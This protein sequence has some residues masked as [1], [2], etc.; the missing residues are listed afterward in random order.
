MSPRAWPGVFLYVTIIT[1]HSKDAGSSPAWRMRSPRLWRLSLKWCYSI[2]KQFKKS[3][4]CHTLAQRHPQQLLLGVF[5]RNIFIL[6]FQ[7]IPGQFCLFYTRAISNQLK[8]ALKKIY[9][10]YRKT[11]RYDILEARCKIKI[12]G[13]SQPVWYSSPRT[14]SGVFMCI[15]IIAYH[16]KDTGSRPV[17]RMGSPRLWRLS[18]AWWYSIV[19]YVQKIGVVPHSSTTSPPTFTVGGL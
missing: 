10:L 8:K 16:S 5:R 3:E 6:T 19:K 13:N 4:S 15:T 12:F 7:K 17:W 14:W 18:L 11:A 2:L 1:Y 9:L